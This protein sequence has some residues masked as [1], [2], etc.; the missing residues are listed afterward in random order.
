[1]IPQGTKTLFVGRQ[2]LLDRL[3]AMWRK[4]KLILLQAPTGAG[5]SML[6][7]KLSESCPIL[8]APRCNCLGAFLDDLEPQARLERGELKI[9]ARVHRL[10]KHLPKLRTTLVIDNVEQVPPRVAH[11]VRV[12]MGAMPVWLVAR[13]SLPAEMGHVWP[14]LFAFQRVDLRPFSLAETRAF[15]TAAPFRGDRGELLAASLR[16]HRLSAGHPAT[17][18]ALVDELSRRTY[19]LR[20][21]E[22]L[23]LLALHARITRV[24]AQIAHA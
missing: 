7:A 4:G 13:S 1:M 21:M 10:V 18:A 16:L 12:L 14:Y 6:I 2:P 5:K 22:G 11:L 20:T 24:E 19:D 3:A 23:H 15:L 8:Y 9:A 17:L